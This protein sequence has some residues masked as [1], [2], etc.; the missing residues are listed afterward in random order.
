[1]SRDE[2]YS[3]VKEWIDRCVALPGSR[4]LDDEI[5]YHL[6]YVMRR[7]QLK[8]YQPL[9]KEKLRLIYPDVYELVS[10]VG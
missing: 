1:L 5:G 6:D 8:P 2:A 10:V 9:S 3:K 4:K 7:T